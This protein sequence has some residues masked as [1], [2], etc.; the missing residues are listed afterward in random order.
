MKAALEANTRFR[1]LFGDL[2]GGDWTQADIVTRNNVRVK[3]LGSGQKIRGINHLTKRPTDIIMDDFES[4]N[5]TATAEMRHK[6]KD[7]VVGAVE[8]SLDD[9]GILTFI[10]TIVHQDSVLYGLQSAPG[11]KTLF[12][13]ALQDDGTALWPEKR[14]A[15]WLE[16]K[17]SQLEAMG[18]GHMFWQ[19]YQ[20]TPRNPN[21]QSYLESDLRYYEGDIVLK[22]DGPWLR[23]QLADGTAEEKPVNTFVGVDL[24]ISSRGD[25]NVIL[26]LAVDEDE[27][28][29]VVDY[30]RARAEPDKVIDELFR[31]HARYAPTFFV[32][33]TTAYQQ[34]IVTFLNREM[35]SRN[36][37]LGVREVKPRTAKD[38]RLQAMQPMVKANKLY[39]KRGHV[40]LVDEL[41]NFPKAR[42]DDV[43]DAL[44]NAFMYASKSMRHGDHELILS[45]PHEVPSWRM[46]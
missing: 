8:P 12:Y 44:H 27:N 43:M 1:A 9:D 35:V 31:F 29:Y 23:I 37:F 4:E 39:L 3:A 15:Q 19:E 38:V 11:Y 24:S 25:Y 17:R 6:L 36:T 40:E 34:A 10:G 26:I 16:A 32:I 13:R 20:N 42:N 22:P 2:V 46:L 18:L 7:W 28:M 5:N 30:Y 21:E 33:E 14:S 45:V 41:V